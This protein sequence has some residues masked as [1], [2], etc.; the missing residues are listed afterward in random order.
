ME[1][2]EGIEYLTVQ[3]VAIRKGV[4]TQGVY[5]AIRAGRLPARKIAKAVLLPITEVDTWVPTGHG[6]KRAG[7]GPKKNRDGEATA[8]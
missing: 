4:T 8:S 2:L 6:G 5:G 7:T 3:E 1:T